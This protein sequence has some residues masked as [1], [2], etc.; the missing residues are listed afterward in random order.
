MNDTK[1]IIDLLLEFYSG[2]K[3]DLR[4]FILISLLSLSPVALVAPIVASMAIE[5]AKEK[6]YI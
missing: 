3:L 6:G 1:T 5:Y 4:E 2:K